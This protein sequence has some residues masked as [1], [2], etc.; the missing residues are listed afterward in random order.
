MVAAYLPTVASTSRP[1]PSGLPPNLLASSSQPVPPL[2]IVRRVE[3]AAYNGAAIIAASESVI[4]GSGVLDLPSPDTSA[5]QVH[6]MTRH[7][8]RALMPEI[9]LCFCRITPA[10]LVPKRIPTL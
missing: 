5:E 7:A 4:W 8:M 9:H 2:R 1:S 3:F 10:P 6:S